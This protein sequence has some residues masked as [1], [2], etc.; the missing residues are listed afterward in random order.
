MARQRFIHPEIWTS[1]NFLELTFQQRLLFIGMFSLADDEGRIKANPKF[2][3]ASIFPADY[4]K[5]EEITNDLIALYKRNSIVLYKTD[6]GEFAHL[7]KWSKYQKPKYPQSSKLPVP[8]VINPDSNNQVL[9][10]SEKHSSNIPPTFPEYSS[11]GRDGVGRVGSGKDEFIDVVV[12][13]RT[14]E[15]KISEEEKEKSAVEEI[16]NHLFTVTGRS[17]SPTDY[18]SITEVINSPEAPSDLSCRLNLIK[19]TMAALARQKKNKDPANGKINSFSYFIKAILAE[20]QKLKAKH[21]ISQ[22]KIKQQE[23]IENDN[24]VPEGFKELIKLDESDYA[25]LEEHYRE[26]EARAKEKV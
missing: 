17:A 23:R 8:P 5:P 12:N 6:E 7:P 15:E 21:N 18:V 2:L 25:L 13:T 26:Q 1:E 24:G 11:M 19:I 14:R 10:I 9:E 3:K 20:Y 22:V 4:V 16:A